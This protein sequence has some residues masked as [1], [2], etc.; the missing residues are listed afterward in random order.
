MNF[1]NTIAVLSNDISEVKKLIDSFSERNSVPN[2]ELDLTLEKLRKIYDILLLLKE[3]EEKIVDV[4]ETKPEIE[5]IEEL[6][7]AHVEEEKQERETEEEVITPTTA[8]ETSTEVMLDVEQPDEGPL[9]DEEKPKSLDSSVIG[10]K[11][12]GS[13]EFFNESFSQ[14]HPV[15]DFSVRQQTKPVSDLNKAIGINDKFLFINEL[16]NGDSQSYKKAI[17][18]INSCANFNEAFS[19]ISDNLHWEMENDNVQKLLDLIRR[20]FISGKN[21]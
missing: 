8:T 21:V 18:F 15:N 10:E 4:A 2:I 16:F 1:K 17:E 7:D 9:P 19:Y 20:K 6:K 5:K 3:D 11:V 14:K 13:K 12:G